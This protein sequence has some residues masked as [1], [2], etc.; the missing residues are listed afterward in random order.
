VLVTE[1]VE[2][3]TKRSIEPRNNTIKIRAH[4][5]FR[6]GREHTDFWWQDVLEDC[7]FCASFI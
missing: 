1:K 3:T 7:V 2:A 4:R 5:I 6:I